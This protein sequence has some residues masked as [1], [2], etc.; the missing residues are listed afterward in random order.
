VTLPFA[1]VMSATRPEGRITFPST[2]EG[3]EFILLNFSHNHKGMVIPSNEL[4]RSHKKPKKVVSATAIQSPDA[5]SPPGKPY[6]K[7]PDK[8]GFL[9]VKAKKRRVESWTGL[10]GPHCMR[11]LS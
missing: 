11:S 10:S 9:H 1:T 5:N 6:L 8:P 2:R 7:I 4:D 3:E